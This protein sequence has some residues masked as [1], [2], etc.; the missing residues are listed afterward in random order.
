MSVARI[1]NDLVENAVAFVVLILLGI[2]SFFITVFVV[3]WG[4]RLAGFTGA[5]AP[6]GD[7]VVLSAALIVTASILAGAL[8]GGYRTAA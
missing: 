2:I 8:S 3:D 6:S 1:L 7:F 5:A 4:S